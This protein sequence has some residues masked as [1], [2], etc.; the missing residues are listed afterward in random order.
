MEYLRGIL[1][2][3]TYEIIY[4]FYSSP[5]A[6]SMTR[7]DVYNLK[8]KTIP[9]VGSKHEEQSSPYSV[10]MRKN[11]LKVEVLVSFIV[12]NAI[13]S[14]ENLYFPNGHCQGWDLQV[15]MPQSTI[16]HSFPEMKFFCKE[17]TFVL[18]EFQ[19]LKIPSLGIVYAR[20]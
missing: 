14:K 13:S 6:D 4:I 11:L 7:G 5:F 17:G 8:Q 20:N 15:E 1:L 9:H 2:N 19:R 3:T 18:L 16:I 12:N 10:G